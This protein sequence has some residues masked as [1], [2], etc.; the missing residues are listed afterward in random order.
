MNTKHNMPTLRQLN[1]LVII[2]NTFLPLIIIA[3]IYW[4]VTGVF[5]DVRFNACRV[6]GQNVWAFNKIDRMSAEQISELNVED[7]AQSIPADL[8]VDCAKPFA[9]IWADFSH[10]AQANIQV[11][12][13]Q[14][15]KLAAK[16]NAIKATL[17][18]QMKAL[19][20]AKLKISFPDVIILRA[21]VPMTELNK[22]GGAVAS[23]VND[24]VVKPVNDGVNS[25]RK[26]ASAALARVFNPEAEKIGQELAKTG[27]KFAVIKQ[28]SGDMIDFD[29]SF[30]WLL[31]ILV[32]W[33]ALSY[34]LWGY[35][36]LQLGWEML[37][38]KG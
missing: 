10:L 18:A 28:K 5:N 1:G 38:Q 15:E 19:S 32:L 9:D 2:V 25:I 35:R 26:G 31:L 22:I 6:I 36:R 8:E 20:L 34:V 30:P 33:L 14:A 7:F 16:I 27:V 13:L 12:G 29:I 4:T 23:A 17:E 24:T 11:A 3:V 21:K 37:C